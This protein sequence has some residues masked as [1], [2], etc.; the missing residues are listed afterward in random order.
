VSNTPLLILPT[1]AVRRSS[2]YPVTAS[3][4]AARERDPSLPSPDA[5]AFPW[6]WAEQAPEPAPKGPVEG[7]VLPGERRPPA[8]PT[9]T[10]AGCGAGGPAASTLPHCAGSGRHQGIWDPKY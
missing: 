8:Q 5:P 10:P 2:S 9:G 7:R 6:G 1:H 3:P 4:A